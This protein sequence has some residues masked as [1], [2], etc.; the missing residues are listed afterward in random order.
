V[1]F[2]RISENLHPPEISKLRSPLFKGK[3][4]KELFSH[5]ERGEYPC[6][7]FL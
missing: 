6:N 7:P 2:E 4:H 1:D 5:D 3:M